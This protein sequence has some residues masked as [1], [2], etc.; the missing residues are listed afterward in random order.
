MPVMEPYSRHIIICTGAF[1]SPSRAG[2]DLY[3]LLPALL[4]QHGLL[5]GPSRVKRSEVPCLGVCAEG[6]IAVVYPEGIWYA[7]LTVELLRR[8]VSEH[9][10]NGRVVKDAVF[11]TLT[12]LG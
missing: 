6:P 5:F 7:P 9:L 10:R 2:R 3:T 4:D 8:I 1:C 11:H 12:P